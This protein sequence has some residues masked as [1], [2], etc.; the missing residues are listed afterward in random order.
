[1]LKRSRQKVFEISQLVSLINVKINDILKESF[2]ENRMTKEEIEQIELQKRNI[3]LSLFKCGTLDAEAKNTVKSVIKELLVENLRMDEKQMENYI[4]FENPLKLT[5][6]DKFQIIL[7][8]YERQYEKQAFVR[9]LQDFRFDR[10]RKNREFY[11]DDSD[12][13]EIYY[14]I[15][16]KL[17]ELDKLE[18]LTQRVYS[19]YRGLGIADDILDMDVDG[20][21]GGVSGNRADNKTLWVYVEGHSIQ[22]R[23]LKFGSDAELER[24]CCNIYRHNSPGH[25]SGSRGYIVNDLADHSRVV[26]ARPPFCESWV[27]FVRKFG[28]KQQLFSEEMYQGKNIQK[29][30]LLLKILIKGC[31]N[32]AITG[33]QGSGKTTLLMLLISYIPSTFNLRIQELAFE[34]HLRDIY[35]NRNIVTFRETGSITGQEGLDLQKKTDGSVNIIGEVAT[36]PVAGWL[37]QAGQTASLFTLFTHHGK[38]TGAMI[39]S[40]ANALLSEHLM[41]NERA[42]IRQVANVVKI[43]IHMETDKNG[44]RIIQRITEIA[45]EDEVVTRDLFC[46]ENGVYIQ[47][48]ELS[49]ELKQRIS[50]HLNFTE[51]EAL[52]HELSMDIS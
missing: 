26:V 27:F 22:L 30:M 51:R 29:V 46:Y 13:D 41:D 52:S 3:R 11:V 9:F 17:N 40:L 1:M 37:M 44:K 18:I 20:V 19:L 49:Y 47:K 33:M 6:W 12:I 38:T 7:Y 50:R 14:G 39:Q 42:A 32:C 25:L 48:N 36:A 10:E 45:Y 31:C 23:F 8:F 43:D 34:L 15:S 5:S 28:H 35:P 21:S 2:Y 16:L 4:P 24:I